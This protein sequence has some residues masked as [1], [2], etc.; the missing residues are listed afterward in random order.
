[1]EKKD[2]QFVLLQ[3]WEKKFK[4]KKN[5][6]KKVLSKVQSASTW[7]GDFHGKNKNLGMVL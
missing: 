3:G 7:K 6:E 4:K 2:I 5:K 1:M